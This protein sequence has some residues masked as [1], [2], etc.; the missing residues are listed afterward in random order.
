MICGLWRADETM[1]ETIKTIYQ[2][3]C[4]TSGGPSSSF[5]HPLEDAL[6]CISKN[7]WFLSHLGSMHLGL[8]IQVRMSI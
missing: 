8:C 4:I 3:V 6:Q 7:V 1:I 2:S 5:D